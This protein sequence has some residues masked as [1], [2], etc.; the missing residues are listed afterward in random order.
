MIEQLKNMIIGLFVTSAIFVLVSMIMFIHPKI[1]DEKQTLYVRFSD[2]INI[3]VGTRVLFAGKP[4]G[5]V[6][7][8]QEIPNARESDMD[9]QGHVYIY[10]LVLHI[11]SSIKVYNTDEVT[12]QTSG[13]LGEKSI[14][15][16]PIAPLPG[17]VPKRVTDQPIYAV[18]TDPIQQAFKELSR[19]STV[20]EGTLQRISKWID[21]N[22][23]N[24]SNAVI[25]F[26]N[27]MLSIDCLVSE[28]QELKILED[29]KCAIEGFS[30]LMCQAQDAMDELS[31]K[32]TFNNFGDMI[33][34]LKNASRSIEIVS[35]DIAEGQG[36]LGRLIKYDDL[37]LRVTAVMSKI[38]TLMND[39]NHYGLLFNQDKRW[40]RIREKR[41]TL[42]DAL[43][44][45]E[46]F[47]AYF[48]QEVDSINTS[49]CRL[50]LVIDKAENSPAKEEIFKNARFKEDFAE[51]LREVN[52]LAETLRYYNEQILQVYPCECQC[53]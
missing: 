20:F 47:K 52:D 28:A 23:E 24:V 15:I 25:N 38:D 11:D 34:N 46:S 5:E 12:I 4:V 42:L 51:L 13:L 7:A 40:Q 27:A 3:N 6:V 32:N 17:V 9:E 1:G 14:A 19:L 44:T 36:T 16:I 41:M 48:Q 18:S 43:K 31:H 8:I 2:I 33:K 21:D 29:I 37:Y 35:Q 53:P 30:T 10:Q 39:I 45:P 50:S 49:V 26:S 22:Y